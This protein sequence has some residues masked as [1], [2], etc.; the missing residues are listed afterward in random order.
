[1]DGFFVELLNMLESS[2]IRIL[3]TILRFKVQSRLQ[4][5]RGDPQKCLKWYKFENQ[6]DCI[7]GF[8]SQKGAV[9]APQYQ[10]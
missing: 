3:I 10:I 5:P 7:S 1:M 8:T 4:G 6:N 9:D 2:L